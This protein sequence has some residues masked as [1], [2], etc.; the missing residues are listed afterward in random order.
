[1]RDDGAMSYQE[2]SYLTDHLAVSAQQWVREFRTRWGL[3]SA[4]APDGVGEPVW[5][6]A[7][8]LDRLTAGIVEAAKTLQASSSDPAGVLDEYFRRVGEPLTEHFLFRQA[9]EAHF[10]SE[11][12]DELE[13]MSA[14]AVCLLNYLS[15]VKHERAR[16]YLA[17]VGACFLRGME[18]E[19]VVMA[20]AVLDAAMQETFDD[21]AVRASGIRCGRYVS[22]GNRIEYALQ[23]D[24][25]SETEGETA[26]W[27]AHE[28]NKAIHAAPG[29]AADP[30]D[31]LEALARVL[32]ALPQADAG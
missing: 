28:R 29:C 14:H 7:R 17:R 15:S 1:M 24:L 2:D 31:I 6:T 21:A 8:L 4:A 3:D 16:A 32:D 10:A 23:K 26:F 30:D 25:L 13:R 22:L 19:A 11:I 5:E 27:V 20:G 12:E 9:L 18:T